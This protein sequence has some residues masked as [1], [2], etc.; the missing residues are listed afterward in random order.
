M[1]PP[2][3]FSW[4]ILDISADSNVLSY[5]LYCIE[6]TL[7]ISSVLSWK[8]SINGKLPSQENF[9]FLTGFTQ[10]F[11]SF[12]KSF[13]PSRQLGFSCLKDGHAVTS[14]SRLKT[15]HY[16]GIISLIALKNARDHWIISRKANLRSSGCFFYFLTA[17]QS[18]CDAG[19]NVTFGKF[20]TLLDTDPWILSSGR[21]RRE[22]LKQT[23]CQL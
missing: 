21:C 12:L 3:E 23:C 16:R 20:Q 2:D 4:I 5:I 8:K 11:K 15:S 1:L 10:F 6:T 17:V 14:K 19:V 18:E 13:H 9:S 7:F 22:E